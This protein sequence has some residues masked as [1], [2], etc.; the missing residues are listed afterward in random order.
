MESFANKFGREFLGVF[1]RQV[2]LRGAGYSVLKPLGLALLLSGLLCPVVAS[3]QPYVGF[4]YM[5]MDYSETNIHDGRLD[6]N[7]FVLIEFDTLVPGAGQP[8]G[9]FGPTEVPAVFDQV[10]D[11]KDGG[12]E[13]LFFKYGY[14]ISSFFALEVRGG[15]G[16]SGYELEGYRE[17]ITQIDT[18]SNPIATPEDERRYETR[19]LS[20]TIEM[21]HY[22]G[23]YA[24]I[25]AARKWWVSPYL[26]VGFSRA[27]FEI[28]G[29]GLGNA[30][31]GDVVK[32]E[33]WGAGFNIKVTDSVFF[34][35]EYLELFDEGNIEVD[36]WNAGL[37]YSF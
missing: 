21:K 36:N 6:P 24:R 10:R 34:S 4:G 35:I 11:V 1:G 14:Q 33:S 23:A 32:D 26:L 20:S 18:Q 17:E 9:T 31:G 15:I 19:P 12:I 13:G 3:A 16:V 5:K 30:S 27:N 8:V 2:V 7:E 37:E 22:Y 28:Q 29:S 25:G